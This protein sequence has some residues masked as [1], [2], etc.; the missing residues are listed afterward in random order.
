MDPEN[1]DLGALITQMWG[2]EANL[3]S[4]LDSEVPNLCSRICGP[5]APIPSVRITYPKVKVSV[6]EE[7]LENVSTG[8]LEYRPGLKDAPATILISAFIAGN[9]PRLPQFIA[10]G[11]IRHWEAL[12]AIGKDVFDYSVSVAALL[13]EAGRPISEERFRELYSPQLVA[14][15]TKVAR[16][17]EISLQDFL[18]P[19]ISLS[20][21][22]PEPEE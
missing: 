7:S 14:K 2:S 22:L 1:L 15:A 20:I 4:F 8:E 21:Y 11:L 9:K 12:G 18:L 17:V 3:Q 5:D 16:D 6:E 19:R 10:F 13:K